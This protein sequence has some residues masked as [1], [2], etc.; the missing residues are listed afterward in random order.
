MGLFHCSTWVDSQLARNQ[1]VA[2][3]SSSSCRRLCRY[4]TAVPTMM[5]AAEKVSLMSHVLPAS[6]ASST[7]YP[8]SALHAIVHG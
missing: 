4:R 1:N 6:A 5:S 3:L 7:P 8:S 2:D